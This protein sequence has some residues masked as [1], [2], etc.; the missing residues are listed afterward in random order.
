VTIKLSD[1]LREKEEKE[2]EEEGGGGGTH[3]NMS[4]YHSVGRTKGSLDYQELQGDMIQCVK[5]MFES[6]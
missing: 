2:E 4:Y 3:S 1:G 6:T 5:M